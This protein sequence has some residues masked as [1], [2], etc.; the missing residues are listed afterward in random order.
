[1]TT[2]HKLERRASHAARCRVA[3]LTAIRCGVDHEKTDRMAR[4]YLRAARL[5]DLTAEALI[6]EGMWAAKEREAG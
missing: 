4:H 2:R 5:A 3:V 1:M 6:A